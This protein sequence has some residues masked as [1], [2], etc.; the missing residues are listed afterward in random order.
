MAPLVLLYHGSLRFSCWMLLQQCEEKGLR[1]VRLLTEP[2]V[3]AT[4]LCNR[5]RSL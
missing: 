3:F 5:Q 4:T 2:L 1:L